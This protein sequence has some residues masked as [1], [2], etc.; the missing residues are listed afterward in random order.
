MVTG[1]QETEEREE[2]M[3]CISLA[4][5]WRPFLNVL[6]TWAASWPRSDRLGTEA[7]PE[8]QA[9]LKKANNFLASFRK[10]R[11]LMVQC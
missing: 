1:R 7:P 6:R 10:F 3:C 11:G 8:T 4:G 2:G 9:W 5:P